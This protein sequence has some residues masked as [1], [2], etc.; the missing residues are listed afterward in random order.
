M[1][2]SAK[3]K[4]ATIYDH[5]VNTVADAIK[6][7]VEKDSNDNDGNDNGNNI[8]NDTIGVATKYTKDLIAG[9]NLAC[10]SLEEI[11]QPN[12]NGNGTTGTSGISNKKEKG[13]KNKKKNKN[14][15]SENENEEI[16]EEPHLSTLREESDN[17]N[18]NKDNNSNLDGDQLNQ[19][20]ED[21]KSALDTKRAE[22]LSRGMTAALRRI[23]D[24]IGGVTGRINEYLDGTTDPFADDDDILLR[25]TNN[26]S[27]SG[28]KKISK[29]VKY[30]YS[31]PVSLSI[32][33]I[34]I[35]YC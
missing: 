16:E 34:Y 3:Q 12:S 20:I 25:N 15:E 21:K 23:N 26:N 10:L 1:L 32:Y 7:N 11:L 8:N 35:I 9:A 2:P 27:G 30:I 19:E 24:E 13:K 22:V 18:N 31:L 14:I 17:T 5:Y 33:I 28:V 6:L 4:T 29:K